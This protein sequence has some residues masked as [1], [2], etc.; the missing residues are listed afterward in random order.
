M[1]RAIAGA[2]LGLILAACAPTARPLLQALQGLWPDRA[3][4]ITQARLNPSYRYLLAS[5]GD[6]SA[7]LVLG[8]IDH[9]LQGRPVEVWYSSTGEVIR[10][11]D[12]RLVGT[13]GL[14]RDWR[15]V[16]LPALPAWG[17]LGLEPLQFERE[18]DEMPGYRSGLREVVT[19]RRIDP[20]AH[21]AL[22]G[23]DPGQLTWFEESARPLSPPAPTLPPA[24]L[25]VQT[26]HDLPQVVYGEQCLS[27]TL[28]LSWQ[29]WPAEARSA[30]N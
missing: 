23:L 17:A 29:R 28:C 13:A 8:Y 7:L 21:S 4:A 30:R 15:E 18:R 10:L 25:A 22:R 19:L 12:G 5:L 26:V 16:R 6:S 27:A 14:P 20:L 3:P 24:H 2:L 1:V 11:L 9:D